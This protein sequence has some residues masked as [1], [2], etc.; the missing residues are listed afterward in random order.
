M[1]IL[2]RISPEFQSDRGNDP[3]TPLSVPRIDPAGNRPQRL[4]V[5]FMEDSAMTPFSGEHD[6]V[7]DGG[8]TVLF[9]RVAE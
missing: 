1:N 4:R 3:S 5:R 9:P 7:W 6:K 8:L 2:A